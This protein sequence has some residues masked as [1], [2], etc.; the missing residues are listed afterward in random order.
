MTRNAVLIGASG[1]IGSQ[2][3]PLLLDSDAYQKVVLLVRKPLPIQH[4]KL[5][6]CVVDFGNRSQLKEALP[7]NPVIFCC[8]GT[9]R[10]KVK[11]NKPAYRKVDH[12]IPVNI[13]QLAFEKG[14]PAYL[15]VSAVG[16]DANSSNFYLQ[17]KGE[18]EAA[19]GKLS[20]P[21]VYIFRPSL[22]LGRRNESRPGEYIAQKLMPSLSFLFNG[23]YSKYKPITASQVANAMLHA[24][25]QEAPGV[26][27][28]YWNE[29]MAFQD[30]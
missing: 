9:T 3:L 30:L 23:K 18:T 19:I 5:T 24:S 26:S 28:C 13:G 14:A 15:L 25:I 27:V 11:G 20:I 4:P 22:L 1:L 2:L 12:D 17:L 21:S 29:M 6:V 7:D 10:K 8:V 16:A